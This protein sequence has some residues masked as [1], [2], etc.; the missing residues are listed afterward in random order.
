VRA[1]GRDSSAATAIPSAAPAWLLR[2]RA[3]EATESTGLT[4]GYDVAD[5]VAAYCPLLSGAPR[6]R[7]RLFGREAG[8]CRRGAPGH[9]VQRGGRHR[10]AIAASAQPGRGCPV[11]PASITVACT[12]LSRAREPRSR[13]W[14]A[15]AGGAGLRRQRLQAAR[16]ASRPR[17]GGSLAEASIPSTRRPLC[18]RREASAQWQ[19]CLSDR[20]SRCPAWEGRIAASRFQGR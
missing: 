19:R 17:R 13:Q 15:L 12:P 11:R 9:G 20:F 1:S 4:L 16:R 18:G 2:I 14:K 8:L 7:G 10:R 5:P 6:L 3:T